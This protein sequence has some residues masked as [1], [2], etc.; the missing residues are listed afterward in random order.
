MFR[1]LVKLFNWFRAHAD[2]AVGETIPKYRLTGPVFIDDQFLDAGL[3]IHEHGVSDGV[4]NTWACPNK[5]MEPLNDLA[6]QA[7]MKWQGSLPKQDT[8]VLNLYDQFARN[9]HFKQYDVVPMPA[10]FIGGRPNHIAPRQNIFYKD[11][12]GARK[13]YLTVD[14]NV[15]PMVKPSKEH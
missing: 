10:V 7:V 15:V 2:V 6:R 9:I 4:L 1:K 11:G 12:D 13:W 3:S 5:N 14:D 8:T